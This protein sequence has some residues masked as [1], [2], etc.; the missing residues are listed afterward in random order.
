MSC[1]VIRINTT[2]ANHGTAGEEVQGNEWVW[3]HA[4]FTDFPLPSTLFD[5]TP[6]VG[7]CLCGGVFSL[8][9]ADLFDRRAG[10]GAHEVLIGR[11]GRGVDVPLVRVQPCQDKPSPGVRLSTAAELSAGVVGD[12]DF[13][14]YYYRAVRADDHDDVIAARGFPPAPEFQR[15]GFPG[16]LD[17]GVVLVGDVAATADVL[18]VADNASHSQ[19]NLSW[20]TAAWNKVL[21]ANALRSGIII[22]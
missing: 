6:R 18:G 13:I 17:D 3:M 9:A 14:T 5:L 12:D 10:G 8:P 7:T 1:A 11:V 15:T 19:T 16:G 20:L 2:Q 4:S 22:P 21:V